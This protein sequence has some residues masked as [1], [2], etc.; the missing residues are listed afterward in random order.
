MENI[1]I[2][3]LYSLDDFLNFVSFLLYFLFAILSSSSSSFTSFHSILPPSCP[4]LLCL[5]LPQF[6]L[7]ILV[8]YITSVCAFSFLPHSFLCWD[9]A[10]FLLCVFTSFLPAFLLSSV[11]MQ[12][13]HEPL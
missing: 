3:R 7:T 8:S 11:S 12:C 13:C 1:F 6:C 2:I 9:L 5:F 10:S 4:Y